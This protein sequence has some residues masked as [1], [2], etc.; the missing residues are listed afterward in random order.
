MIATLAGKEEKMTSL[1]QWFEIAE[2]GTSG[3]MVMDILYAWKQERKIHSEIIK[4]LHTILNAF[5]AK[6]DLL[7]IT[8][9]FADTMTDQEVLDDLKAWSQS[10]RKD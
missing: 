5:G 3:D 1:E 6:S 8:G 9:S 7:S 2:N 10:K 4:Q